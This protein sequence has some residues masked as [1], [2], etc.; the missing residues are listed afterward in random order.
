MKVPIICGGL[1]GDK[2]TIY[3]CYNYK[4]G[5]YEPIVKM[6]FARRFASALEVNDTLWISGGM[7]GDEVL[8]TTEMV[9]TEAKFS[10]N[11][12]M[13]M[14]GHCTT[15]VNETTALISG[16]YDGTYLA[17]TFFINFETMSIS[18]GPNLNESRYGHGCAMFHHFG[19]R[20][21]VVAGGFNGEGLDS[22][23]F[24]HLDENVYTWI[25]GKL[26]LT[27]NLI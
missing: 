17:D 27:L 6:N 26:Q 12:P 4:N 15:K 23:E 7:D 20:I 13:K 8:Q 19:K 24:L 22:A 11:L 25:K 16:G 5:Q 18:N 9:G 21:A 2:G 1:N 14:A 3:S 10:Q